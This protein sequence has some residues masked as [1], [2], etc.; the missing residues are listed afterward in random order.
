MLIS[1]VRNGEVYEKLVAKNPKL[2]A[3]EKHML[4]NRVENLGIPTRYNQFLDGYDYTHPAW[5]VF[6][7]EDFE[8]KQDLEFLNELPHDALYGPIGTRLKGKKVVLIGRIHHSEKDG[9]RCEGVGHRVSGPQEV[10]TFDCQCMIVHSD[11]VARLHL[12][13]D[14]NLPFDLYVEDF[15]IA[16]AE[17]Y[18]IPSMVVQMDCQHYSHG[19]LQLRFLEGLTYMM[20]KW[21]AAGKQYASTVGLFT[22]GTREFQKLSFESRSVWSKVTRI[23]KKEANSKDSAKAQRDSLTPQAT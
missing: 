10:L 1:V 13:F 8:L 5:F 3:Y 4:D 17:R 6:C 15:C 11:L 14:E 2:A 23:F 19:K 12:R 21:E 18:G 9:S 16:A 20:R 22:I 7:H